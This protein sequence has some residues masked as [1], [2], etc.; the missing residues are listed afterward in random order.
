MNLGGADTLIGR[1]LFLDIYEES[2]LSGRSDKLKASDF[3]GVTAAPLATIFACCVIARDVAADNL[4]EA[5]DIW[6]GHVYQQYHQN[7]P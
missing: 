5:T 3:I 2:L 7:Q 6:H 4:P 1:A